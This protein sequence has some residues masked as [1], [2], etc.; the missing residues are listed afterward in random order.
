MCRTFLGQQED[1][2]YRHMSLAET[3]TPLVF[4]MCLECLRY[5]TH[6]SRVG[7]CSSAPDYTSPCPSPSASAC[8]DPPTLAANPPS[9]ACSRQS[10]MTMI[11]SY[12]L[13]QRQH[14]CSYHPATVVQQAFGHWPRSTSYALTLAHSDKT[15]LGARV[16]TSSL[17]NG[18]C[19]NG[20]GIHKNS[21]SNTPIARSQ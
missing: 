20:M 3:D 14:R 9:Y 7:S 5:R 4:P 11:R 17:I 10:C 18:S 1:S 15:R 2:K 16:S 21:A 19:T 13:A 8:T 6:V 12:V